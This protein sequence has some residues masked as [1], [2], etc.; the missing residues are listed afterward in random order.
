MG[1]GGVEQVM[2]ELPASVNIERMLLDAGFD[3]ASNH[4]LLREQR[5]ILRVIPRSMA[6]RPR[7]RM[8]CPWTKSGGV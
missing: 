6:G 3:S 5:G 2:V 8:L 4:R 1:K 7:I